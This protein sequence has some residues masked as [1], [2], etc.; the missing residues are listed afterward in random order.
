[1]ENE[2]TNFAGSTLLKLLSLLDMFLRIHSKNLKITFLKN[3][4][5]RVLLQLFMRQRTKILE[6]L[7]FMK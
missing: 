7:K 4:S 2:F 6:N 3:I 1:M 5:E